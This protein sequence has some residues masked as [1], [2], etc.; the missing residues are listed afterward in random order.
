M[1]RSVAGAGIIYELAL[2]AWKFRN[3]NARGTSVLV[4]EEFVFL[5]RHGNTLPATYIPIETQ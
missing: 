4:N 1:I 3:L 2:T 5:H